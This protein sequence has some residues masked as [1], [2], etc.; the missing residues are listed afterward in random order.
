MYLNTKQAGGGGEA[1]HTETLN[2]DPTVASLLWGAGTYSDCQEIP[3]YGT[4]KVC[5][6]N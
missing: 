6:N 2:D 3:H 1:L 4:Q 5:N